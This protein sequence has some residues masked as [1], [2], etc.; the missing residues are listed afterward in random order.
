MSIEMLHDA[1]SGDAFTLDDWE[2]TRPEPF[3]AREACAAELE[4]LIADVMAKAAEL[5]IPLVLVGV[6]GQDDEGA[7]YIFR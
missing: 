5:G 3:D 2:N 1:R 6:T 4:P 7:Y